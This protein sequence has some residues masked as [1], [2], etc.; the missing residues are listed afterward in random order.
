MEK[1]AINTVEVILAFL[2]NH[3]IL[4]NIYHLLVGVALSYISWASIYWYSK[5][6]FIFLL[7]FKKSEYETTFI[8]E[9]SKSLFMGI[10]HLIMPMLTIYVLNEYEP[11]YGFVNFLVIS[12]V[13]NGI[14]YKTRRLLI[15]SALFSVYAFVP[16]YMF[17][18]G[19]PLYF[20]VVYALGVTCYKQLGNKT[21]IN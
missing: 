12:L 19:A 7:D 4:N 6:E 3:L 14:L 20:L 1:E 11:V 9:Y 8:K 18:L 21:F 16:Y 13:F 5:K 17:D 2:R 10:L 15:A